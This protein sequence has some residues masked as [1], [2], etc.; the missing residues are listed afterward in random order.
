MGLAIDTVGLYL[1]NA[2]TT[3]ETLTAMTA[4]SGDSLSVRNYNPPAYAK[5]EA[6]FAQG[7]SGDQ[8]RITSPM[9]HDDVTGLTWGPVESPAQFLFPPVTGQMLYPSDTLVVKYGAAA[10]ASSIAALLNYYSDLPGASARLHMWGDIAGI[11]KA[12]KTWEV[13]L[14]TSATIGTWEDTAINTTDS[15][16]H[17]GHDYAILGFTTDTALA[18]IAVKGQETGNLR[19]GAPGT[20][21]TLDISTYFV[22]MS[23]K[24]GT[25]HIPVFNADNKGSFY[26]SSLANTASVSAKVY[27]VA[28]ELQHTITP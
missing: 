17:A 6:V 20:T 10:S 26:V 13:D 19:V 21:D 7:V 12:V 14:T 4:S 8:L 9:L 5:L 18:C 16:F 2:A 23:A 25:P 1:T 28:A 11:I 3:A 24:H 27:V 22:D 15:Q